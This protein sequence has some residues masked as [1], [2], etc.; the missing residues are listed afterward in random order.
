M[1]DRIPLDGFLPTEQRR[2]GGP[3]SSRRIRPR[4]ANAQQPQTPLTGGC[5]LPCRS[6]TNTIHSIQP[7]RCALLHAPLPSATRMNS[8][9]TICCYRCWLRCTEDVWCERVRRPRPRAYEGS[10]HT[11]H[12]SHRRVEMHMRSTEIKRKL[13]CSPL[14][15]LFY[16]WR[17]IITKMTFVFSLM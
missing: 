12:A 16:F 14:F 1:V 11:E 4:V 10:L 5:G 9:K 17:A 2:L 7:K 13:R 3:D 6:V 15:H 8:A